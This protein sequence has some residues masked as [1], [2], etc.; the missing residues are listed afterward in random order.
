MDRTD[1]L[2]LILAG[3]VSFA[4]FPDSGVAQTRPDGPDWSFAVESEPVAYAFDGAGGTVAY[5]TG[6]WTVS[7]EGFT[8]SR[9]ETLHGNEGFESST[10]GV[11]MQLERYLGGG[12][13]GFYLGPEIGVSELEVTHR[14]SGVTERRVGVSV[15]ARFGYHWQTG[16]GGL[17]LN[18]VAGISY[19]PASDDIP[20]SEE[21]FERTSVTPWATVGIGWAF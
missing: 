18:P 5:R 7:L 16:L 6:P 17:Y 14:E 13:D 2:G 12:R 15:G 1:M 9:P 19:S 21:T 11:Q 10:S 20:V 8:L 3:I 4:S